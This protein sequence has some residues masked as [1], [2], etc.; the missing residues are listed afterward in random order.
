MEEVGIEANVIIS[1]SFAF[2]LPTLDKK[3]NSRNKSIEQLWVPQ[4]PLSL[5]V[6]CI[7]IKEIAS[8]GNLP[9]KLH[10]LEEIR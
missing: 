3:R 10:F 7:V 1:F 9:S 4:Y 6:H 2:Y 5:Q 8:I